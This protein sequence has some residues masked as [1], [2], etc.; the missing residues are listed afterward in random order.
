MRLKILYVCDIHSR[1]EELS[2][3]ATAIDDLKD[4]STII[5][6]AG[7][8]ADFARIETEGTN[9]KI[10][11]EILNA[12]GFNARVFGNNEGF[13][14]KINGRIISESSN[15]P[16]ITCNMYN[17]AGKK[18]DYLKDSIILTID[19]LKILVIGV[20]A[21]YNIFYNLSGINTKDPVTEIKRVLSGYNE[22]DYD[23][24]L[25]LSHLGLKEDKQ[26]SLKIPEIDIIIGG[27]SHIPLDKPIEN[28]G[29]LICQA[30][31]YG[32]YLGVLEIKYDFEIRKIS[33]YTGKLISCNHF[34]PHP[35]ISEILKKNSKKA[36]EMLSIPL[37]SIDISLSHS[38][39]E[40]NE[41]GNILADGLKDF[42]G[43]EIGIIN[44][45]VL[46]KGIEKGNVSKL[47]LHELCP[48]PLNP[49]WI[50]LQGKDLLV[51]L[52]KSL[53]CEYNLFDGRGPGFRGKWLGNLQV[54]NN[55]EVKFSSKKK[56][57][58]RLDSVKINNID[59]DPEKWYKIATSDYL[60]RGTGYQEMNNCRNF[61]Y[62][63]EFLRD[64][65]EIYLKK[66]DFIENSFKKRFFNQNRFE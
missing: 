48:S 40:E 3:I 54:S 14:G 62:K 66:K 21:P 1:Y 12:I 32:E 35:S 57:L 58:E 52:E 9:G 45:G 5:L 34:P 39:T 16:S 38:L 46:N 33:E 41:I 49:T 51:S 25:L 53:L 26:I 8:N 30:G 22:I 17:M 63:P 36:I 64:I 4:N 55:V 65:L 29:V 28:N 11:S 20:T 60:Q 7:D 15:F 10:S 19:K 6:D 61:E 27:H 24:I 44:S 43:T 59:I 23:L 42:L 56:A 13:S 2:K 47:I 50:E 37:Y 31:G 18:L